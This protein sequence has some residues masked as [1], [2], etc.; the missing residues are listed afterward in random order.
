M[1]L[2]FTTLCGCTKEEPPEYPMDEDGGLVPDR[3]G[4]PM[5]MDVEAAISY[6]VAEDRQVR[7]FEHVGSNDTHHLFKE[8]RAVMHQ[9]MRP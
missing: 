7:W 5:E 1:L 4:Q 9:G 2:K 8:V 3:I 6:G